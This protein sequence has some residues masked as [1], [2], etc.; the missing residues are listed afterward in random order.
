MEQGL[1]VLFKQERWS[2]KIAVSCGSRMTIRA[3]CQEN[4]I[5]KKTDYF[6]QRWLFQKL[7]CAGT[8]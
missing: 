1:Q 5:S 2:E 6:W 4:G 7:T 3:W 8:A